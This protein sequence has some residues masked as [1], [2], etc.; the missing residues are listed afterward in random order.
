MGTKTQPVPANKVI[1]W[2]DGIGGRFHSWFVFMLIS[3]FELAKS[4][5]WHYNEF[6]Y[7]KG[8][9]QPAFTCSKLTIETLEQGAKYVQS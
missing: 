2:S 9:I 6:Y 4:H 5:E 1:V 7:G 3:K 8:S